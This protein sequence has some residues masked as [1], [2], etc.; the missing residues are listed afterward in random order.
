MEPRRAPGHSH[1]GDLLI[2]GG[3]I[4]EMTME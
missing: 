1:G 3:S 2:R 4:P